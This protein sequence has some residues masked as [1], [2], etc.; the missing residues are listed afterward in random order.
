MDYSDLKGL[1]RGKFATQEAFAKAMGLSVCSVNKKL[2]GKTEWNASDI[3]KAT[4][5]LNIPAE[6]IPA[7]F[8]CTKS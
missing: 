1:I 6:E 4:A 3:R 2:N 5:L 7:Y 8:F